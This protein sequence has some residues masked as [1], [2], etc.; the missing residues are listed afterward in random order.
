MIELT[1]KEVSTMY[2]ISADTLRYYEDRT[3]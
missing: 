1:I 3:Y 2:N